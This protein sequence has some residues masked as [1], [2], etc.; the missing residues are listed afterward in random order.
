VANYVQSVRPEADSLS[1]FAN[2]DFVPLPA[3]NLGS[4]EGDAVVRATNDALSR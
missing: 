1:G 4:N 2:T 3:W